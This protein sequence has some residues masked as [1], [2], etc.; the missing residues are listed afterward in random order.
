MH[1]PLPAEITASLLSSCGASTSRITPL[2]SRLDTTTRQLDRED[3]T[4]ISRQND[5]TG[6]RTNQPVHSLFA[7]NLPTSSMAFIEYLDELDRLPDR[8]KKERRD[9]RKKMLEALD[10]FGTEMCHLLEVL[11]DSKKH[12]ALNKHRKKVHIEM[13]ACCAE[14]TAMFL[15]YFDNFGSP[16]FSEATTLD[17]IEESFSEIA[18]F[19]SYM[20][21]GKDFTDHFPVAV[22]AW[23]TYRR[24]ILSVQSAHAT[25]LLPSQILSPFTIKIKNS[26]L[27]TQLK[28]AHHDYVTTETGYFPVHEVLVDGFAALQETF[29]EGGNIA[30]R[31]RAGLEG[32]EGYLFRLGDELGEGAGQWIV[33]Q[34]TWNKRRG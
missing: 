10:Y 26:C 19:L 2:S 7:I 20:R 11:S 33:S 21:V 1:G 3:G 9:K 24:A 34:Q 8:E 31:V 15:L 18:L 12:D 17:A 4:A 32:L 14:F 5:S 27:V 30:V 13:R 22:A 28:K 16:R 23:L 29:R 25:A 6:P